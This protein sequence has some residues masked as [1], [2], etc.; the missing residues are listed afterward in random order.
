ML[1]S[2]WHLR[3]DILDQNP[4]LHELIEFNSEPVAQ[5]TQRAVRVCWSQGIFTSVPSLPVAALQ[6]G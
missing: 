1:A 5:R 4:L 3:Q 6:P 2:L